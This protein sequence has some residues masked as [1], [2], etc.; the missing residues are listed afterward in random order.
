MIEEQQ[1]EIERL[2]AIEER[3]KEHADSFMPGTAE[4]QDRGDSR[5]T[6]AELKDRHDRSIGRKLLGRDAL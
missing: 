6:R 2:T 1:R 3:V 4:I 5:A